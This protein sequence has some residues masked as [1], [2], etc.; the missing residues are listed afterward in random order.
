[1]GLFEAISSVYQW[2]D[3]KINIYKKTEQKSV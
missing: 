1:M 3:K 2:T